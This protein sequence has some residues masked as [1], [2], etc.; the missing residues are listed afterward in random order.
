[1]GETRR[2]ED[3]AGPQSADQQAADGPLGLSCSGSGPAR[4]CDGP[5]SRPNV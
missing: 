5:A 2:A 4:A 3:E 1:M